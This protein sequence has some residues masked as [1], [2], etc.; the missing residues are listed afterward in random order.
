MSTTEEL[1]EATV[2]ADGT[3]TVSIQGTT[4]EF[5]AAT[6]AAARTQTVEL[7]SKHAKQRGTALRAVMHD[8][9]GSWPV[10]VHPD[11]TVE[12][13]TA[14][15]PAKNEKP[16]VRRRRADSPVTHVASAETAAVE[17]PTATAEPAMSEEPAA[18]RET[19][20]AAPTTEPEEQPAMELIQAADKPQS[21][22]PASPATATA[23]A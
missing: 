1:I 11:G 7:V 16:A 2:N 19:P 15:P 21:A 9:Q 4:H 17:E 14:T 8:D 20:A 13:D 6:E 18:T 23:K 10:K 3:A 5:T 12:P 22:A